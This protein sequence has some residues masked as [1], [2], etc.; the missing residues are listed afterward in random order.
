[1]LLTTGANLSFHPLSDYVRSFDFFEI[2]IKRL[3]VREGY[4]KLNHHGSVRL[5]ANSLCGVR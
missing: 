3:I 2:M 4:I 1:M 5:F